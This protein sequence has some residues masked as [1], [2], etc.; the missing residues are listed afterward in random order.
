MCV[1]HCAPWEC[2]L[3]G[4]YSKNNQMKGNLGSPKV[5]GWW[6]APLGRWGRAAS[7][8]EELCPGPAGMEG[9]NITELLAK[10]CLHE[11]GHLFW[12]G[13]LGVRRSCTLWQTEAQRW[14]CLGSSLESLGP[15]KMSIIRHALVAISLEIGLVASLLAETMRDPQVMLAAWSPTVLRNSRRREKLSPLKD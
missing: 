12:W 10:C 7:L 14:A 4:V 8:G 11:L 2:V 6:H 1:S 5:E 13:L 9:H 3:Q 15:G